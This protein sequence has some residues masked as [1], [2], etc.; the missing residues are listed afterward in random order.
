M[1][2]QLRQKMNKTAKR[3]KT[4]MVLTE[5]SWLKEPVNPPGDGKIW[6]AWSCS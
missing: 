2:K 6:G 1:S 4:Q 5:E 3:D